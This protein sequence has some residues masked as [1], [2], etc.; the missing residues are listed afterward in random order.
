[1]QVIH[2]FTDS[3]IVRLFF[4]YFFV[5]KLITWLSYCFSIDLIK[6]ESLLA[7]QKENDSACANINVMPF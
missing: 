1:M 7:D 5:A 3:L 6:P 4:L 2:L